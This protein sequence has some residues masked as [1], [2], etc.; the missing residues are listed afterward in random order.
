MRSQPNYIQ[1]I[2]EKNTIEGAIRPIAREYTIPY[3]IGRGYS[4][5]PPRGHLAERFER[6]GKEELILL[7]LS[8]FDPEGEDIGRSFAQSLRDDFDID[9]VHAV[10]VALT[11]DQ[12]ETLRLPPLMKAKEGSSRRRKFVERHGENVHELE[13]VPPDT[14]QQLLRDAIDSVIDIDAYNAE[15]DSE[16]ED[17]AFLDGVRRRAHVVLGGLATT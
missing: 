17:A 4:S 10:K 9:N 13:S 2:G 11:A 8:D 12:V 14:L 3:C 1:I 7:V 6:S 16:R 5:L 15:I